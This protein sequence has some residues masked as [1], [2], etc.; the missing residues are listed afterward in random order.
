[1]VRTIPL[2]NSAIL[3]AFIFISVHHGT[4]RFANQMCKCCFS[5]VTV[6]CYQH[7]LGCCIFIFFFVLLLVRVLSHFYDEEHQFPQNKSP[8]SQGERNQCETNPFTYLCRCFPFCTP[9]AD[10]RSCCRNELSIKSEGCSVTKTSLN[11]NVF[12]LGQI[13][14]IAVTCHY[15]PWK[16]TSTSCDTI[17]IEKY[18]KSKDLLV[19]NGVFLQIIHFN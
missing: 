9:V 8:S 15:T 12:P 3:S 10:S 5:V 11:R 14:S 6:K 19:L 2:Q 13:R 1:M 18:L 17:L 7:F 4:Q 16:Q